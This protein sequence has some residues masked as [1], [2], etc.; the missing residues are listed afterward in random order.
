MVAP[1]CPE[2]GGVQI[3]RGE[4]QGSSSRIFNAFALFLYLPVSLHIAWF[5]RAGKAT[6]VISAGAGGCTRLKRGIKA[7][8][9]WFFSFFFFFFCRAAN[10]DWRKNSVF[11]CH[12]ELK[13]HFAQ[14]EAAGFGVNHLFFWSCKCAGYIQETS[15]SLSVCLAWNTIRKERVPSICGA[16]PIVDTPAVTVNICMGEVREQGVLP[17][18]IILK[19]VRKRLHYNCWL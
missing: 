2:T 15:H 11:V 1:T 17:V 7:W 4:H 5:M 12:M 9:Q 6:P 18:A 8:W 16:P 3:E 14:E 13:V 10:A 19:L